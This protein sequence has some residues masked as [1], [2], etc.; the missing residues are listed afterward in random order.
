[1]R[2]LCEGVQALATPGWEQEVRAFFAERKVSLGG[3]TL[4]Q[5]L[6]QLHIAVRLREREGAALRDYLRQHVGR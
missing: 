6:E 3:K 4:E 5:Y 1:M 2:R